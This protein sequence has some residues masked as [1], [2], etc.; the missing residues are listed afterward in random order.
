MI[1]GGYKII[2]FKDTPFITGGAT[3]MIEGIYDTVEASY[4]KPLLLSGLNIDGTE[5]SDVYATPAL[6]GS[7]FVFTAYGKIITI[8]DTDA[9]SVTA[10]Q[11]V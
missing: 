11:E 1:K 5:H 4:R 6:S 9:V 3:M 8:Q 2:D 7:N 10:E